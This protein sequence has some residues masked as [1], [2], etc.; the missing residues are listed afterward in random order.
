M[1]LIPAAVRAGATRLRPVLLTATTTVIGLLP[2]A[3]GVSFDFHTLSWST[4]SQSSEWW[5]SMAIAVI[6]GLSFATLVTLVLVPALY[7]SLYRI[8]SR[9]GLGGL[10]KVQAESQT[11]RTEVEDF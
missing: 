5:R 6:Y 10:T 11:V 1:E 7:V 8:A 2:M 4:R 9:L 3:T